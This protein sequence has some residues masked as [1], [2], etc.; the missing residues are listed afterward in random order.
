MRVVRIN[1]FV[2]EED[3]VSW[4][5]DG[6]LPDVGWTL[7]YGLRGLGKTTFAMQLCNALQTGST[8]LGRKT[9]QTRIL[10]FQ[11]DSVLIEWREM[12]KRIT[13]KKGND[14]FTAIEIPQFALLNPT[15][16]NS[17]AVFI[18]TFKPGFVVFDSLYKLVGDNVSSAKVL[19]YINMLKTMCN[20]RP[21]LLI[22]HPP[23]GENRAAG[24]STLGAD[25]SNEWSLL[26]TKLTIAKGR[27]VKEGAISLTRDDQGLWIPYKSSKDDNTGDTLYSQKLV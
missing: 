23:H 26:K 14:G 11:A 10:Y 13:K 5:V 6:L 20:D 27:L 15:Y 18:E 24:S 8:F 2:Q 7:F 9:I 4:L 21:W 1:K 3:D 19:N 25:C 12:L 22:H 16:V 17:M